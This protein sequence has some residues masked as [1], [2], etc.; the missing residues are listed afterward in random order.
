[1]SDVGLPRATHDIDPSSPRAHAFTYAVMAA[2][3]PS[4]S[5][6]CLAHLHICL[7]CG[8]SQTP[9]YRSSHL[10][11]L[12]ARHI[13]T[14]TPRDA[15]S[16]FGGPRI[17]WRSCLVPAPIPILS[18]PYP[19]LTLQARTEYRRSRTPDRKSLPRS[20]SGLQCHP[21]RS[22]SSWTG[23]SSLFSTW[24]Y[25]HSPMRLWRIDSWIGVSCHT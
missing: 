19:P 21:G 17:R 14:S 25:P 2:D 1:M 9:R 18:L 13:A 16:C 11:P 15:P 8:A 7:F 3:R 10:A 5:S 24:A 22:R 4:G 23:G 12:G 20:D 6:F